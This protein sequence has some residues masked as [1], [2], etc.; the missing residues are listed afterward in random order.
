MR[1]AMLDLETLGT[2][3]G[4]VILSIGCVPFELDGRIGHPV[5]YENIERKSSAAAGLKIDPKTVEWWSRQSKEAQTALLHPAPR[6]LREV[7]E[8]FAA[9]YKTAG[10][11]FLWGHGASFDPP[12]W[13]TASVAVGILAPW[14]FYNVRDTRTLYA[15]TNF[16]VRD[17]TKAHV[18]HNAIDDARFQVACVTEAM[19]RLKPLSGDLFGG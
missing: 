10:V 13:E 16:D 17:I 3:P 12:L 15:L 19:R 1:H 18:E 11:D 14:K 4:S 7:A 9:W 8:L 5:F 6:P 2:L